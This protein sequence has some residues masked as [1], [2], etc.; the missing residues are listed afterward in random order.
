MDRWHV[1]LRTIALTTGS[2]SLA[3]AAVH[4]LCPGTPAAGPPRSTPHGGARGREAPALP[5]AGQ[6]VGGGSWN[7]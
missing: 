7:D 4:L 3:V 6:F 1:V 2:M 5:G